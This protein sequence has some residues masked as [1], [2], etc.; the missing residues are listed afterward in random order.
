[1]ATQFEAIAEIDRP[2]DDVFAYLADG[3]N[4]RDF[5]PRVRRIEKTPVG[6]T[7]VGT[8]FR[9][10]VRDAGMTTEREFAI[11]ELVAPTRLRW[12]EKSRNTVAAAD[13]GYDLEALADG[14]TRV[15]IFNVLEGRGVGKLLVGFAVRAARKDAPAF[16]LRIKKAVEA[17]V[18]SR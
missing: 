1:M 16:G 9:S 5:S 14:R 7:V 18:P 11:T 3:E 2:I 8:V 12:Q 13:G 4:D 15:R 17:A 6:P 10:T